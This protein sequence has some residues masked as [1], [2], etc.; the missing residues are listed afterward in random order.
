MGFGQSKAMDIKV[1][2]HGSEKSGKTSIIDKWLGQDDQKRDPNS[3]TDN[4]HFQYR[5]HNFHCWNFKGDKTGRLWR[6]YRTNAQVFVIM[7]DGLEPKTLP[8]LKED[9]DFALKSKEMV[10]TLILIYCNKNDI[11]GAVNSYQVNEVFN[12]DKITSHKVAIFETSALVG[13]GVFDGLDWVVE[14]LEDETS[15]F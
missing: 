7:I 8:A 3:I 9:L 2:V 14:K 12:L 6:Q 10:E 5:G 4:H 11:R 13:Y 1:I 15:L